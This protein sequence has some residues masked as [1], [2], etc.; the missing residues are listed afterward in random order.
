[1]LPSE[2]YGVAS[3]DDSIFEQHLRTKFYGLLRQKYYFERMV[4]IIFQ[5][6]YSR[7]MQ[8]CDSEEHANKGGRVWRRK[9]FLHG[10]VNHL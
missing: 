8:V 1:V 7:I 10:Q 4:K 5:P 3:F 6:P 2:Y 9:A